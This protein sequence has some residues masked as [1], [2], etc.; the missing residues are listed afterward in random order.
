VYRCC[1]APQSH[2]SRKCDVQNSNPE[3]L[4]LEMSPGG[5]DR[6]FL[7]GSF[8]P[9]SGG[10]VGAGGGQERGFAVDLEIGNSVGSCCAQTT[11]CVCVWGGRASYLTANVAET[12]GDRQ[13]DTGC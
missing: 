2:L 3:T 8:S 7:I 6:F 5:M 4:D 1:P 12:D 11:V 9:A 13:R 10:G